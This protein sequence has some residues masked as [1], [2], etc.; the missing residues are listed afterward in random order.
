MAKQK[1]NDGDKSLLAALKEITTSEDV[2][3][4]IAFKYAPEILEKD[5]I[6]TFA[7]LQTAYAR[8]QSRDEKNMEKLLYKESSQKAIKYLLKRI[9]VLRD[10]E[11]LNEYY[12]LSKS[13]NVQALKAYVD[14]KKEVLA[15]NDDTD[16]LKKLLHNVNLST[17]QEDLKMEI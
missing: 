15:N 13:G 6:K 14:F 17:T 3:Y 4:Y 16:E 7:D 11:L 12:K 5:N 9:D 10:I 8:F 2:A 1:T